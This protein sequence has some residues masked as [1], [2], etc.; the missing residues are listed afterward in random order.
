MCSPQ[1]RQRPRS[2]S[3]ET[4]GMLSYH[5]SSCAQLMHAEPG[6]MI[7][8]R[9]GTRAATTFRNEP[10]ARPGASASAATPISAQFGRE[11]GWHGLC[12]GTQGAVV[13]P[14]C[15]TYFVITS[16]PTDA[17]VFGGTG[18]PTGMFL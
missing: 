3:H 8:R 15:E 17:L 7:E 9:S 1:E 11:H 16:E 12:I 14:R 6:L 4:S 18:A 5:A 13:E 10:K 2:A